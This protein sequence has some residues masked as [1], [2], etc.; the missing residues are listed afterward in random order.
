MEQ[1]LVFSTRFCE[2]IATSLQSKQ[3]AE[4]AVGMH[5]VK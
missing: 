2:V 1:N 4:Q 3:L 5:I